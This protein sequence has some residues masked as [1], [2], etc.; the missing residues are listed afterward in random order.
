[1]HYPRPH[2]LAALLWVLVLFEHGSYNFASTEA[3][4]HWE[5]FDL[6]YPFEGYDYQTRRRKKFVKYDIPATFLEA[7]KACKK[8]KGFLALPIANKQERQMRKVIGFGFSTDPLSMPPVYW[9]CANDKAKEGK[10]IHCKT[11]RPLKYKNFHK[12]QPDNNSGSED[13]LV[14]GPYLRGWNDV[15]CN[16]KANGYICE[17]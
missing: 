2:Q 8:M 11:G 1:M 12:G 5:E 13:C 15:D 10:W 4:T 14:T 16:I 3:Q 7:K 9:L 17:Y 6:S